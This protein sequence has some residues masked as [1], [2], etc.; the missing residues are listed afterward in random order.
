MLNE[1]GRKVPNLLLVEPTNPEAFPQQACM[2]ILL[3]T[4]NVKARIVQT[5]IARRY[6]S[7]VSYVFRYGMITAQE[8]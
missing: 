7:D 1:L 5:E 4:Y 3:V 6:I 2:Y 8:R